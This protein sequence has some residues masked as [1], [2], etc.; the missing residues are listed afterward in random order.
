VGEFPGHHNAVS[1]VDARRSLFRHPI[2]K[3]LPHE[4][5]TETAEDPAFLRHAEVF[6]TYGGQLM[7]LLTAVD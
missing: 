3:S 7:H 1:C 5:T 6:A 4:V 2:F